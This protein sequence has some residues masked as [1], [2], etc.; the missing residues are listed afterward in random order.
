MNDNSDCTTHFTRAWNDHDFDAML[1]LIKSAAP[2]SR[3]L[4]EEERRVFPWMA[5]AACMRDI[6]INVI[7]F[8]LVEA[9][10]LNPSLSR[11]VVLENHHTH[12]NNIG[13]LLS[14]P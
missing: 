10:T 13:N 11:K 12:L 8:W 4:E 14:S 1:A 7:S 5:Q 6:A 9:Q 3:Q 2:M